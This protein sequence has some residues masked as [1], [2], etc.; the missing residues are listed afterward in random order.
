MSTQA[1]FRPQLAGLPHLP[2]FPQ[3]IWFAKNSDTT[4]HKP[5]GLGNLSIE[6][7]S[8]YQA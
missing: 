1:I 5:D 2:G 3:P 4:G 8:G 7:A 6:P